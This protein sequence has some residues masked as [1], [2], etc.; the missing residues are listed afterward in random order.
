[1]IQM[2]RLICV[3]LVVTTIGLLGGSK[4]ASASCLKK[5]QNL[6]RTQWS[7]KQAVCKTTYKN[8]LPSCVVHR[9]ALLR[10]CIS[11]RRGIS[12]RVQKV[13]TEHSKRCKSQ[14]RSYVTNCNKKSNACQ[15][16]FLKCQRSCFQKCKVC[17]IRNV[18]P[19]IQQ[20]KKRFGSCVLQDRTKM[21]VCKR[22]GKKKERW[23]IREHRIVQYRA[24]YRCNE[25]KWIRYFRCMWKAYDA[26][27]TCTYRLSDT[28][29]ECRRKASEKKLL[30]YESARVQCASKY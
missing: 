1:M 29:R 7:E 27:R 3:S 23:C 17:T 6:C 5:Q 11:K 26:Q 4:R 25:R 20:C 14:A 19:C 18:I 24:S 8:S 12:C 13:N 16:P 9:R 28:Y 15:T 2:S 21:R 30:C 22:K 10:A